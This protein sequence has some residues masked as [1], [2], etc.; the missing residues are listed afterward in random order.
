MFTRLRL[1][2]FAALCVIL[3]GGCGDDTGTNNP[4]ATTSFM[5]AT[6]EGQAWNSTSANAVRTQTFN[7]LNITGSRTTGS[8]MESIAITMPGVTTTGTYQIAVGQATG[9]ITTGGILYA[10]GMELGESYG[11]VNIT[12]FGDGRVAGT[13]SMTVYQ[14]ANTANPAKQVTNGSFDIALTQ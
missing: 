5:N 1:F 9:Q 10:M 8:G 7:I 6:F 2:L 13:F 14:E 4:P 3:I 12:K 11:Q